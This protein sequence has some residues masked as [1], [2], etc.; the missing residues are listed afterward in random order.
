MKH[1]I[2]TKNLNNSLVFYRS[3]FNRMPDSINHNSIR[4]IE[5]DFQL[6]IEESESDNIAYEPIHLPVEDQG[7]LV[8][9]HDRMK[10]FMGAERIKENCER[11]DKTIG[12]TDLDGYQWIIGAHDPN[13]KFEKCYFN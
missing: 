2:H 10:R 5:G 7:E 13:V 1:L 11:I 6:R 8:H 12:L 3:L 4:F 9:I